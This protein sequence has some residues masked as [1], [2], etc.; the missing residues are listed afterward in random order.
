MAYFVKVLKSL[1]SFLSLLIVMRL[2]LIVLSVFWPRPRRSPGLVRSWRVSDDIVMRH[3]VPG[4]HPRAVQSHVGQLLRLVPRAVIWT[5]C[6]S[7]NIL[8]YIV[9]VFRHPTFPRVIIEPCVV[10]RVPLGHPVLHKQS[11]FRRLGQRGDW[12]SNNFLPVKFTAILFFMFEI[13]MIEWRV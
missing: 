13:K 9:F 12:I 1:Q 4:L 11:H 2:K 3:G 7:L 6:I 5:K 10:E 8:F